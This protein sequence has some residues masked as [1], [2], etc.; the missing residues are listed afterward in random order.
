MIL[1][2]LYNTCGGVIYLTRYGPEFVNTRVVQMCKKRL[3]DMISH[4]TGLSS[5]LFSVVEISLSFET[6][7]SWGA[8]IV[9][10]TTT[11][12]LVSIE[13]GFWVDI[14]GDIQTTGQTAK[15]NAEKPKGVPSPLQQKVNTRDTGSTANNQEEETGVSS[16]MN[17]LPHEQP[18]SDDISAADSND[19]ANAVNYS[20][21]HKLDWTNNKRDW[22]KYVTIKD[23]ETNEILTSCD[24]LQPAV[25]MTVTPKRNQLQYMFHSEDD[26]NRVLDICKPEGN[27]PGFALACKSWHSVVSNNIIAKRPAGHICD[28][29]I[30]SEKVKIYFW[31]IV[32]DSDERNSVQAMEYLM[33]TGRMIKHQLV[34]NWSHDKPQIFI[35]CGLSSTGGRT[36]ISLEIESTEMQKHLH[37][38]SHKNVDFQTLQHA[39][40]LVILSRESPLTRCASDQASILLSAKQAETLMKRAK[41]NYISGA[42]G[43][44]KSFVAAEVYRLHGAERSVYLCT[45]KPFLEFLKFSGYRGTLIQCDSDLSAEINKR[46]FHKKTYIIIDDSHNFS[47]SESSMKKL[48]HLLKENREMALFVFADNYYQSFDRKRQQ[49][50]YDCI[51]NLTRQVL[52]DEPVTSRLTEV[53]RNTRKVVSFIQSAVQDI[54]LSHYEIACAHIGIGEGIECIKMGDVLANT[55]DNVLVQYLRSMLSSYDKS[56]IAV[57]L[58]TSQVPETIFQCRRILKMQ[59]PEATFQSASDFPRT[60]IIVD[61]VDSFLGLDASLCIFILP[62]TSGEIDP[63]RSLANPR[64]R[65]FLA[66]RATH[67][68]VFVVPQ[69][70]EHLVKQMKFDRFTVSIRKYKK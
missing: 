2:A 6:Q 12:N 4:K 37:N 44:G 58:D 30:V 61:S 31:V 43:S 55:P 50:M 49:A 29:L 10:P 9:P 66:S 53:Y 3:L 40:A 36:Q 11:S 27:V 69:I 34:R 26:M 54:Q 33:A 13:P 52:D 45:T 59:M 60:G 5:D 25:P 28:I 57:F 18:T 46:T 8:L 21:F 1:T 47:C 70:D 38:F 62:S 35:K 42:A 19:T 16:Y 15:Q 20:S 24:M 68:A 67:K 48:F 7:T 64:Y 32:E 17:S 23:V 41:V 56:V 22:E 65:V 14:D 51:H 63:E 39:V